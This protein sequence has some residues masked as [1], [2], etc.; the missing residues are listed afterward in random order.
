MDLSKKAAF[1]FLRLINAPSTQVDKLYMDELGITKDEASRMSWDELAKKYARYHAVKDATVIAPFL[2]DEAE[3]TREE[4]YVK[5]FYERATELME[6]AEDDDLQR[7]YGKGD[8][9]KKMVA[10]ET[11]KRAGLKEDRYGEKPDKKAKPETAK[12][13][14]TYQS[15]RSYAD[16]AEDVL[17]QKAKADAANAGDDDRADAIEKVLKS[18]TKL[19]N[20]D[21]KKGVKGM[22]VDKATDDRILEKIRE[23]RKKAM[24]ELGITR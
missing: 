12:A 4:K 9:A 5:K 20:G 1:A 14:E 19:R 23:A 22:G 2:S 17:L 7:V 21:P 8:E 24:K 13:I 18:I 6:K 15:K 11:A 10:K 3:E 16:M